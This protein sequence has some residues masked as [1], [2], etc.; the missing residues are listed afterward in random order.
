MKIEIDLQNILYD[1]A[2]GTEE[3]LA[4]CIRR[5]VVEHIAAF[6]RK[7]VE[8]QISEQ[9]AKVLDEELRKAVTVQMPS[10]VAD[11][12]DHPYTP[13][14]QF[15]GKGPTTT[16]RAELLKSITAQMVYKPSAYESD[17]TAF[18]KAVDSVVGAHLNNFKL[19]FIKEVDAKFLAESMAYATERLRER[20]GF[21]KK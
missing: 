10:L 18:T 12:L 15:G 7:G 8:K 17:R 6:A 16:F 20:L 4:E 2:G 11:L 1:E 14:S 13:I 19:A 3:T 21:P 5:Q 9:V